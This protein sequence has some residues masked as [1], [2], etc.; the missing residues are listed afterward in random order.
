MKKKKLIYLYIFYNFIL[1][2]FYIQ[3]IPN[4]NENQKIDEKTM[5][6]IFHLL[7]LII[8]LILIALSIILI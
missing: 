8:I 5:I 7:V 3:C 6:L 4:F 1:I 2:F